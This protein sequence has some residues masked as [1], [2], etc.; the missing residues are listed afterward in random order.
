[1]FTNSKIQFFLVTAH[2]PSSFSHSLFPHK[3][4]LKPLGEPGPGVEWRSG[5]EYMLELRQV[6]EVAQSSSRVVSAYPQEK[7]LEQDAGA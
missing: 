5:L 2:K 6:E 3:S 1:M 7:S 4:V